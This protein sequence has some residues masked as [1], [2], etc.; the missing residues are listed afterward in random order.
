MVVGQAANP[1]GWTPLGLFHFPSLPLTRRH[2][3]LYG[4]GRITL[5]PGKI[6]RG[7]QLLLSI[8]GGKYHRSVCRAVNSGE[9]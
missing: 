6:S 8:R 9:S 2:S 5:F 7:I 3:G 1:D 4:R